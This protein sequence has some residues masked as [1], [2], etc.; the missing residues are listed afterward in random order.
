MTYSPLPVFYHNSLWRLKYFEGIKNRK[1]LYKEDLWILLITKLSSLTQDCLWAQT[2]QSEN[3]RNYHRTVFHFFTFNSSRL[4]QFAMQLQSGQI[5]SILFL[6]NAWN[7]FY[8]IH[9][10]FQFYIYKKQYIHFPYNLFRSSTW[11]LRRINYFSPHGIW[12]ESTHTWVTQRHCNDKWKC[13]T[14]LSD[15]KGS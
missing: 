1:K 12:F 13:T 2:V 11:G 3:G 7:S 8:L 5:Q 14:R 15:Q 10:A 4:K 6:L 9:S